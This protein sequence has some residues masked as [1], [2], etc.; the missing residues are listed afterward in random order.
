MFAFLVESCTYRGDQGR[1]CRTTMAQQVKP[2]LPGFSI[3]HMLKRC[4]RL[5]EDFEALLK[6]ITPCLPERLGA[7]RVRDYEGP[8]STCSPAPAICPTDA[9]LEPIGIRWNVSMHNDVGGLAV[10]A[11]FG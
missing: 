5:R 8:C 7:W 2:R 11:F 10:V 9:L 1:R 6:Q 3:H 4:Y